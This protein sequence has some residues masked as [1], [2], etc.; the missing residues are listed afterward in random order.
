MQLRTTSTIHH[1]FFSLSLSFSI[2][3]R[4]RGQAPKSADNGMLV[5]RRNDPR[6]GPNSYPIINRPIQITI[7]DPGEQ[8][9]QQQMALLAAAGGGAGT[10][11]RNS[12]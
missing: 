9:E 4:G 10:V 8:A 12:G 1:C 6:L 11:V 2:T 3:A 7:I 5:R